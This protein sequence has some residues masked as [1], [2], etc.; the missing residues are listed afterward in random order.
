MGQV[1]QT[2]VNQLFERFRKCFKAIDEMVERV[3]RFKVDPCFSKEVDERR[4]QTPDLGLNDDEIL[5][6]LVALIA[7]SNNAKSEKVTPLVERQIFKPIFK[8]YR[9]EEAARL[10]AE[11]IRRTHWQEIKSIRFKYK[12]DS[13]VRC[14]SCLIT[15]GSSTT[16][17][18]D[19]LTPWGSPQ[20]SAL[21]QR[22]RPFGTASVGYRLAY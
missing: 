3:D 18:C 10:S 15:I 16:H 19:S 11:D 12:V 22:Y 14:A 7:Y 8:D 2:T 20:P 1:K 21:S 9:T 5:R 4:N 13:M 6:L 17:L